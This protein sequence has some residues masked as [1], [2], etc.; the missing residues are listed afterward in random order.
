MPG[1]H[2]VVIGKPGYEQ[3]VIEQEVRAGE[4]S[5]LRIELR[6]EAEAVAALQSVREI[7]GRRR[8]AEDRERSVRESG[9]RVASRRRA[10]ERVTGWTLLGAGLASLIAAT[11]MGGVNEADN[12]RIESAPA[13]ASWSS[14]DANY[15]R[16]EALR[17][18]ITA[19]LVIG[20]ALTVTASVLLV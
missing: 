20:G 2:V 15:Q 7:E 5:T 18:A 19:T 16:G 4:I 10:I 8:A 9:E 6:T 11:A 1:P 14:V 13:W 3:K 17:P 12:G